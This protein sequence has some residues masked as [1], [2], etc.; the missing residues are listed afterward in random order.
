ME[1]KVYSESLDFADKVEPYLYAEEE[2]NSLF[3]GVLGQIKTGRYEDYFLATVEDE[4]ELVAAC[5]MTP[6]YPLELLIFKQI[7]DIEKFIVGQLV[8]SEVEVNGVGG[9]QETAYVFADAW[10]AQTGDSVKVRMNQGL[11][12]ID[13]LNKGWEKSEGTWKVASKKEASL[14][15]QWFMDFHRE[16]GLPLYTA[17]E[18]KRKIENF[19][20][21]KEIYVWEV[22]GEVV[23]SMKKSRP[24]RHGI[25]I[26]FVY[27]PE[28][29]RG[30]GYAKTLVAEVTEELLLEFDF[31]LLYTDLQNP[32][33]NKIYQEIG[34]EEIANP[35]ELLFEK[36]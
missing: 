29:H 13:S 11:L 30:K 26:S 25:S 16:T 35:V 1:W 32:A 20:E 18:N 36:K 10:V 5:L 9:E 7:P 15:E 2:K 22:D 21:E 27:T 3:I 33:S 24:S 12:R 8:D 14:L 34:Y 28:E 19:I 4:G 31:V 6:P 23:S 17:A